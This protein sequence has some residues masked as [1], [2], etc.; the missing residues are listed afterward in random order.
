MGTSEQTVALNQDKHRFELRTD[1]KLSM[2]VFERVDDHT[3]ALTHTEVHPDLEGQ[4]IG[5]NLVKQ[6][7]D[8]VDAHSLKIVP[9][10]P[11]VA[12]YLKRHPDYQRVVS[13]QYD[14]NDF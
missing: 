2:V 11:F 9:L 4:G 13:G 1:G 5:S 3:L 12:T 10:C 7:L 6:V 8:Y 14:V